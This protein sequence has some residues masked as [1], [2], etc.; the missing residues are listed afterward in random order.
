MRYGVT[1][2]GHEAQAALG[3]RPADKWLAWLGLKG[4]LGAIT[5]LRAARSSN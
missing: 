4:R 3:V 1:S 2:T 5:K